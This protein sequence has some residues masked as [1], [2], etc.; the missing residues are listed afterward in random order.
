MKDEPLIDPGHRKIQ[1]V[2]R[3]FGPFL[4]VL[5]LILSAI[6]LF[7]FF[8]SFGTFEFPRYFWCVLVG[9]PLMGVGLSLSR[10][11]YLGEILRYM[12]REVAPVSKETFNDL[13]EGTRPGVETIARAVGEGLRAGRREEAK[14]CPRCQSAND[15]SARFCNQCGSP[16]GESLCPGCGHPSAPGARFCGQCGRSLA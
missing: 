2:L 4:V 16:L 9:F 15:P 8:S 12:S 7:S 13:A 3:T 6:G 10:V 5:G 11:G 14:T 1:G